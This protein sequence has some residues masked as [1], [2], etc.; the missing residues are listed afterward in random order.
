MRPHTLCLE[1]F[2]PYAAPLQLSFDDLSA[3]GLFLIHGT[4]GAGKTFLLD[5]LCFAL[6]G[7]VPGERPLR[8]LRSD[9]APPAAVPRVS[10]EFST[11]AG[12]WRVERS[13]AHTAQRVR[14]GGTTDK[15]AQA[16]LF[17]LRGEATEPVAGRT[18]EVTREVERLLGLTAAQFQQVILLPQGRFAEVLRARADERE[19]LLKTLFHSVLFEQAGQWLDDQARSAR[20]TLAEHDRRLQGLRQ[21]AAARWPAAGAEPADQEGLDGLVAA[22]S[23]EVAAA[24]A[25]L[26][27]A[28]VALQQAQRQ[29]QQQQRLADRWDRRAVATAR[30]AELEAKQPAVDDYRQRLRLADQAEALRASL[31]AEQAARQQLQQQQAS[32]ASHLQAAARARAAARALPDT[33]QQLPLATL[34]EA[35]AL[36]DARSDLAARRAELT[37]LAA[38]AA[39]AVERQA[40]ASAA[41]RLA[42]AAAVR[43]ERSSTERT[44]VEA[45]Q[46]VATGAL[47]QARSAADRLTGLQQAAAEARGRATAA[48]AAASAATARR[49]AEAAAER[50]QG[51]LRQA[52]ASL[53]DLRQRQIAGM[54]ARL[55]ADLAAG[56][57]CPVCG[58]SDHPA[59]ARPAADAVAD[60]DLQAAEAALQAASAGERQV[61]ATLASAVGDERVLREKAGDLA[62][63]PPAAAAAAATAEAAL[64]EAQL[65]ARRLA[66]LQQ[67]MA[68]H[69]QQL[70]RLQATI[71]EAGTEQAVQQRAAAEARQQA[72]ALQAAVAAALGPDLAPAVVL[73]QLPPLEAALRE[74]ATAAEAALRAASRLD[75]AAERLAADLQGS[76]FPDGATAQA[77]LKDE[78]WRQRLAERITAWERDCSDRRGELA[79]PDLADL[80][81]ERPDTEAAA[82]AQATADGLRT[83]AVERHS[84]AR[85]AATALEALAADHRRAAVALARDRE[86]AQRLAAV[87]D[88]CS[89][90]A[91]PYISLQRWVLSAYLDE[92]CRHANQRLEQM[93]AGRYQ[94]QL[95]DEGGR[96]GRNAGL[97]LRVLDAY[98]GDAREVNSLSGGETF[99]ASLALAL[100]VADTVQ[101]HAGGVQ[102]ETLFIDEGFGSLDPDSLQLAMDELDRLRA[103]GR[104][105]GVISHVAALRERIRAGIEVLGG[106]EGSTARITGLG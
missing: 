2:G 83:R 64:A 103:G 21:Q 76:P 18:T 77:A 97:G 1:A 98:T 105:I 45:A 8:S 80:P 29:A 17:R 81:D 36:A 23:A 3:E 58:A 101:A 57:P 44:A 59:P 63:D 99:Q 48:A 26:E 30:L 100:G 34:P 24:A 40:A 5:A 61:A 82:Q 35:E 20:E 4:T 102:L 60:A 33:V 62:D 79:S 31:G 91:A 87:A 95:S 50:A 46:K 39:A 94:L 55:A 7:E 11:A 10:L 56:V 65:Q 104:L 85:S 43:L 37:A 27:Q 68:D 93:T 89:G 75:Q 25:G 16:V 41:E 19:A 53:Q 70:Q 13:P 88:R 32:L 54:A 52:T 78:D 90:R 47:Q 12:R 67:T 28:S 106:A 14:G 92:I 38:Q 69:E 15:A 71:Q 73:G 6:Y 84:E 22:V 66:D 42:Q 9:H 72:G 51:R 86:K 49:Q 96:G 74:L